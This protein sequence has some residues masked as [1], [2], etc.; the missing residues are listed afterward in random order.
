MARSQG[1]AGIAAA[2]SARVD[3]QAGSALYAT[4]M[5]PDDHIGQALQRVKVGLTGLVLELLLIGLASI[6]TR[7]ANR[8]RATVADASKP[9]VVANMSASNDSDP[10][11]EPLAEIGV[12]PAGRGVG[13]DARPGAAKP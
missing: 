7:S 3:K 2:L 11:G 10:A 6:V 8:D 4:L 9:D 13:G 12:A 1:P 5:K